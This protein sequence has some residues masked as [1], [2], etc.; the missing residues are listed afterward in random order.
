MK[1][2]FITTVNHNVGDDFVRAG[3]QY[4]LQQHFKNQNIEFQNIHKHACITSRYG[5]ERFRNERFS[6]LLDKVLPLFVTRDRMFDADYIVQSGAPVY[7]CQSEINNHCANVDWYRDLITRRY[8]SK[9]MRVPFLNLAAGT[10]LR[11]DSDGSEFSK[12]LL[13]ALHI[14][15]LFQLTQVTTL[16]DTLAQKI[17]TKLGCDAPVIPCS[18]IF[19]KDFHK[20]P[21]AANEYVVLNYMSGGAHYRFGQPIDDAQ[22][23]DNF[24]MLYKTIAKHERVVLS[25]HN[26]KEIAEA[27]KID[28]AAEIFYSTDYVEYMKFYSKAKFGILNR[29][30]GAFLIASYG[31]PAFVIGNDTRALMTEEIGLKSCFVNDA[32]LEVLLEQYDFLQSGADNFTQRFNEIK[33]TAFADYMASLSKV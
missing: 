19:A 12:C 17:L 20:I 15:K 29:V 16:R 26:R 14:V 27:K 11:Y 5:F 33:T 4:L 30:H 21:D 9:K 18:S 1:I 6:M 31:K 13:C 28:A 3:L 24:R 10:C 23:E 22:W 7:W 2:T 32:T 8:L 25:C